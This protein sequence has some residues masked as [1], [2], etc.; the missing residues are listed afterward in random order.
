MQGVVAATGEPADRA[1]HAVGT[2]PAQRH[3]VAARGV[4]GPG[5]RHAVTTDGERRVPHV[6]RHALAHPHRLGPGAVRP[7]PGEDPEPALDAALPAHVQ[8]PVGMGEHLL[9]ERGPVGRAHGLRLAPGAAGEPAGPDPDPAVDR[10]AEQQPGRAVGGDGGGRAEQIFGALPAVDHRRHVPVQRGD[11]PVAAPLLPLQPA[12]QRRGPQCGDAGAGGVAA[13]EQHR[14]RAASLPDQPGRGVQ[15]GR[16]LLE[17]GRDLPVALVHPHVPQGIR[18]QRGDGAGDVDAVLDRG[19]QP[20]VERQHQ[21]EVGPLAFGVLAAVVVGGAAVRV[22]VGVRALIRRAS[23][24]RRRRFP[25][26]ATA[27]RRSL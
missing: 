14:S 27:R 7:A 8:A 26:A 17:L 5:V 2:D 23:S 15:D 12:D 3:G 19:G 10:P 21:V 9:V 25:R 24:R 18:F 6:G 4:L 13:P 22:P 1:G 20:M 16:G 11:E